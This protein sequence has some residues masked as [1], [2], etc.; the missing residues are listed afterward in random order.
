MLRANSKQA[1]RNLFEYV[2]EWSSDRLTEEGANLESPA[3]VWKTLYRIFK[4]EKSGEY[5]RRQREDLVFEDWARGLAMDGLFCY[6][7]NREAREDLA[8]ILEETEEDRA[9]FHGNRYNETQAEATLTYLIYNEMK[10][11]A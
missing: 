1:K 4:A 8:R 5:Y 2:V 11:N 9:K 6:Y 7:Y 10:R 3:E